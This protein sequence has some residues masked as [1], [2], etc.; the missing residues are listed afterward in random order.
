MAAELLYTGRFVEAEEAA[1]IGLVSRVVEQGRDL[2]AARGV[3]EQIL[4]NSP[5]GIRMTKELLNYSLDAPAL[6]HAIEM[7]NRT[8]VLC[9]MTEDFEEGT[10][11]FAERRS[12][13][14][15]DR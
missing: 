1:A 14:Y 3:A 10:K 6:R 2:E 7:E 8:Q 4:G 12:A 9:L 5:F 15:T 11:A 13:T